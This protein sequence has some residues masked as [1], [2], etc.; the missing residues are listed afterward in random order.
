MATDSFAQDRWLSPGSAP[1]VIDPLRLPAGSGS[2]A[3]EGRVALNG[4]TSSMSTPSASA[5]SWTTVVSMLLPAE[6]PAM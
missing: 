5:V 6:P 1:A 3:G 4:V 2:E